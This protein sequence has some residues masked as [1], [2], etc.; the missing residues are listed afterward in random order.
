M[1]ETVLAVEGFVPWRF[2]AA[3]MKAEVASGSLR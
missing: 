2:E 1:S 3:L